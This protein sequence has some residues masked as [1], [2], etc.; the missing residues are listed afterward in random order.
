MDVSKNGVYLNLRHVL[1]GKVMM[2]H[3]EARDLHR[4]RGTPFSEKHN[5]MKLG[6]LYLCVCLW[7]KSTLHCCF[8]MVL[9]VLCVG[10]TVELRLWHIF[11]IKQPRVN[12]FNGP[13]KFGVGQ[14][15]TWVQF[16]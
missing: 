6:S 4:F 3:D 14:F 13:P 5:W 10:K 15:E 12:G 2:K 9:W 8:Y 1:L 11:T 7:E 16:N